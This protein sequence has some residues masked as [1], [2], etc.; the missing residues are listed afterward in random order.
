AR[1]I[2]NEEAR[3][4]NDEPMTKH[5]TRISSTLSYSH[6]FRHSDFLRHSTFGVRHL[7][8]F[9]FF[10]HVPQVGWIRPAAHL[11][12]EDRRRSGGNELVPLQ[13]ELR[14]NPIACRLIHFVATKVA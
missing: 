4:T 8:S 13:N 10:H 9:R 7:I 3:M 6:N 12:F 2:A 5:E 14:I 11:A 1:L